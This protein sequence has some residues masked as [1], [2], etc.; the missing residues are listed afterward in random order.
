MNYSVI[1]L[2]CG[3]WWFSKWFMYEW[4]K[5]V[6]GV[7]NWDIAI[8]TFK[9]AHPGTRTLCQDITKLED[10]FWEEYKNTDVIIAWPPC[11]GFSMSWKRQIWDKRNTLFQEVIRATRIVKPKVV[12]IENVVWLLSMKNE[13]WL[14]IKDTIL[15]ELTNLWYLAYYKILNASDYWVPQNRKRVIF[16]GTKQLWYNYPLE[17]KKKVTVWEALSNIPDSWK[18]KYLPC[19]NEYQKLMWKDNKWKLI[20]NHEK[21]NHAELIIKR[22]SF[23]PQGWNWR[24]IPLELWQGGGE[25][26]NNYKRLEE[27]S[28]SITLKHA[29]KS[30]I[31]HPWYNRCLTPREACRLQSF[32]DD[33][34]LAGT[35]FQQH[36][37]LANAVPPLLWKHIAKSV[38]SYIN[39]YENI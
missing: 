13:D 33:F 21:I 15:N 24:N 25:H 28:P 6:L 23:V 34:M 30:M 39:N 38:K 26:S 9:T 27:N 7:D 11:Q 14:L 20:Y 32:S 17:E 12:I 1:D 3:I 36:Q 22:M 37:Q 2:F 18:T 29:T 4:F 35:K 8:E 31:I 16:V 5:V 19:K 10:H